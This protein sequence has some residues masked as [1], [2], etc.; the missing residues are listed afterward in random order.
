VLI[1][2]FDYNDFAIHME[3]V[4]GHELEQECVWIILLRTQ[5]V[6]F[7]SRIVFWGMFVAI[8]SMREFRDEH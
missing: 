4:S 5:C 2:D 3:L 7:D 8:G 6:S 1:P